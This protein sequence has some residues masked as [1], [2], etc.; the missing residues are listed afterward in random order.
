MRRKPLEVVCPI[1][2]SSK[3]CPHRKPHA[4]DPFLCHVVNACDPCILTKKGEAQ[5]HN[6][7]MAKSRRMWVVKR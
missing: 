2:C 3:T 7:A 4:E 1:P 5:L 6:R